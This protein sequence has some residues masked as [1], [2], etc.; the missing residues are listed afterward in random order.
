M[1][2]KGPSG[3]VRTRGSQI[4]VGGKRLKKSRNPHR[5]VP[6]IRV[7]DKAGWII[8]TVPIGMNGSYTSHA[9]PANL[10]RT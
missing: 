2:D 1:R 5:L 7:R 4:V 3:K 8:L 10:N 6:N 9:T